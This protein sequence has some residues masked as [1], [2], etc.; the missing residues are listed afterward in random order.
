MRSQLINYIISDSMI[1]VTK[2]TKPEPPQ[3][4]LTPEPDAA[5]IK[6]VIAQNRGVDEKD[7]DEEE[8][9]PEV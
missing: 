1:V 3:P 9:E 8:D 4:D 5:A 6:K 7:L 2:R